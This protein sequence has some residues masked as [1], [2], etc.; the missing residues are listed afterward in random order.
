[1]QPVLQLG[2]LGKS[3]VELNL[4]KYFVWV[5]EEAEPVGD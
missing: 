5:V 4:Y 3:H 2:K 1:M